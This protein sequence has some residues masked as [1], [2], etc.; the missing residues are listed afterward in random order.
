MTTFK[1]KVIQ[2][3]KQIP[4]GK[5]ATYGQIASMAD[6]PRAARQVGWILRG[7]TV[8]EDDLPWWR[9]IN[10]KGYISIEQGKGG[11]EKKIQADMLVDDGVEVSDRYEI[12]LERYLWDGK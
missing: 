1:I 6:S 10:S 8:E 12:N 5:V 7:L 3:V 11:V 4:K 9:V 2:I